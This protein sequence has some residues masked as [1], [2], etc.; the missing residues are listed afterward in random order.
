M[1]VDYGNDINHLR[2]FVAV[3]HAN[4]KVVLSIRGTFTLSEIVVDVAAFSRKWLGCFVLW[5]ALASSL[6]NDFRRGPQ[7]LAL[8]ER[9]IQKCIQWRNEFGR[10]LVGLC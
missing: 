7:V 6:T 4:K 2:H 3:D 10:R 9:P 5:T 8:E 1:D